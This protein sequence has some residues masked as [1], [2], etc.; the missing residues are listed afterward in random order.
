MGGYCPWQLFAQEWTHIFSTCWNGLFL[1][2]G[3]KY[4]W[5]VMYVHYLQDQMIITLH[6]MTL[7]VNILELLTCCWCCCELV[8]L[9]PMFTVDWLCHSL[10][11]I[12][13]F[14]D[15]LTFFPCHCLAWLPLV[16]C[17]A[18]LSLGAWLEVFYCSLHIY[19][20]TLLQVI[21]PCMVDRLHKYACILVS[22]ACYWGGLD[23]LAA[24]ESFCREQLI[25]GW[26][27][28]TG[29]GS[30]T[31]IQY[32]WIYTLTQGMKKKNIYM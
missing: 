22:L 32:I 17:L 3:D 2:C 29:V 20:H 12:G 14:I 4:K 26:T 11:Q 24:L 7:N 31:D 6:F 25:P 1:T 15:D 18:A 19:T 16:W 27:W 5:L 9:V 23:G 10:L 30:G 28:T 21:D 13:L 8:H